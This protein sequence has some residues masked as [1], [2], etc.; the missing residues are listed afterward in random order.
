VVVVGN[1]PLGTAAGN[2]GGWHARRAVTAAVVVDDRVAVGRAR[3]R[4]DVAEPRRV[5]PEDDGLAFPV[6]KR[7]EHDHMGRARRRLP[8]QLH[9]GAGHLGRDSQ[10]IRRPRSTLRPLGRA[11]RG[12]AQRLAGRRRWPR[13]TLTSAALCRRGCPNLERDA[14]RRRMLVPE[15]AARSRP[16][17]EDEHCQRDR[18][19]PATPG[20]RRQRRE[21]GL[22]P[23]AWRDLGLLFDHRRSRPRELDRVGKQP[24]RLLG[25]HGIDKHQFGADRSEVLGVRLL[26]AGRRLDDWARVHRHSLTGVP[27]RGR[28]RQDDL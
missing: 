24:P 14:W 2:D 20:A 12:S 15:Q 13:A 23:L 4:R 25:E 6:T 7:P 11:R 18:P 26:D 21:R 3:A 9:A 16:R 19:W 5:T 1:A 28:G 8:D 17:R 10:D 22:Q 27:G